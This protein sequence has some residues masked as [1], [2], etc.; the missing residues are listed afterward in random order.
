MKRKLFWLPGWAG[1]VALGIWAFPASPLVHGQSASQRGFR[2][3]PVRQAAQTPSQSINQVRVPFNDLTETR[4]KLAWLGDP[5]TFSLHLG[6]QKT[7][8]GCKVTGY[9]PNKAVKQRVLDLASLNGGGSVEDNLKVVIG[10]GVR[11]PSGTSAR[12]LQEK[13]R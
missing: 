9:I 12:E 2:S 10:M 7:P 3:T 5:V 4:I 11:L 6:V 1:C 8:T 13:A